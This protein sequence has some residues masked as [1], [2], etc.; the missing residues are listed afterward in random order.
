LSI[1]GVSRLRRVIQIQ[2]R[3]VAAGQGRQTVMDA[4][5]GE[6]MVL[7][8][9][10]GAVVEL[11]EGD[12][13]VYS[14][15]TGSSRAHVGLR[16]SLHGSISGLCVRSGTVLRCDDT[17]DDPRVDAEACRAIGARS[18]VVVPLVDDGGA[19]VGVLKVH[20]AQP[21]CFDDSDAE[22]LGMLAPLVTSVLG[23]AARYEESRSTARRDPLTGLPNR[24]ML[25]ELLDQAFD[26]RVRDG[27]VVAVLFLDLDG[28][29]PVN[30]RL[31]HAG[32]DTVLAE[33]GRRLERAV[34]AGDVATRIGGDEFVVV[35]EL[36]GEAASSP[37]HVA[38]STARIATR[39]RRMVAQP[40]VVGG[41]VVHVGVSIGMATSGDTPE[42][43]A[44]LLARADAAMYRAKVTTR[45]R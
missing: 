22:V 3:I 34:R 45:S 4:V 43:P 7:T 1:A 23:Q 16:L 41:H 10:D 12:E 15:A 32:G 27:G 35:A 8:G 26:R 37:G 24:R 29:K 14:A 44:T 36:S 6:A 21:E 42:A 2:A 20:S 39:I 19:T 9:G 11:A 38:E 25:L 5:A 30:D 28:F 31:G 40:I 17:N 18:M 33:V 13:M